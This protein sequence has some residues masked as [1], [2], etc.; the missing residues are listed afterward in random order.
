MNLLLLQKVENILL[1]AAVDNNESPT[2]F[3]NGQHCIE[4]LFVY[5]TKLTNARPV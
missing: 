5:D 2:I 1:I 3:T 4:Y